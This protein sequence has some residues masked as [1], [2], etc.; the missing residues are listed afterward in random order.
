MYRDLWRRRIRKTTTTTILLLLLLPLPRPLCTPYTTSG[1]TPLIITTPKNTRMACC[2]NDVYRLSIIP[3]YLTGTL[4]Y[5]RAR[6]IKVNSSVMVNSAF[7]RRVFVCF[8]VSVMCICICACD[9]IIYAIHASI[10]AIDLC[11]LQCYVHDRHDIGWS[12]SKKR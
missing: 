2:I 9:C 11:D 3:F 7:V 1:R 8:D 4:R 5:K 6:A 10:P 12:L